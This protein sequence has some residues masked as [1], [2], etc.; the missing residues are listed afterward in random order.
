MMYDDA[1]RACAALLL[2]QARPRTTRRSTA[3][4]V[5]TWSADHH[6]VKF[7]LHPHSRRS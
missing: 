6:F 2:A 4:V 7:V 3:A 5:A 1:M